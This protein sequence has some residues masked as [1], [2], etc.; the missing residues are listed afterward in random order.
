MT[1]DGQGIATNQTQAKAAPRRARRWLVGVLLVLAVIIIMPIAATAALWLRLGTGPVTL[2]AALT[3]R[4]TTRIDGAMLANR[5]AIGR[6]QIGR[7]SGDAGFDMTIR[8]LTMTDPDGA[9]RA[10]FPALVVNL[11]GEALLQGD[12]APVRVDLQGAGLRLA[13]DATG[14]IDLALM[15]GG[16]AS[17][18]GLGDSLA[19]LERMLASPAFARLE[20]VNGR[21]LELVMADAMTGQTMR[22]SDARMRLE[23]VDGALS[24]RIGGALEGSRDATIDIDLARSAQSGATDLVFSFDG[25]AARD[26]ATIGPALAWV[27]LLRAPISGVVRGQLAADGGVGDLEV[28][29]DIGAGEVRPSADAAPIGFDGLQVALHY[30]ATAGRISFDRFDLAAPLVRF[31]ANGH[32]DLSPD[33][34]GY[35]GQFALSDITIAALDGMAAPIVLDTAQIDLALTL[36]P[37]LRVEIGQAVVA[38]AGRILRAQGHVGAVAGGLDIAFDLA[39]PEAETGEVLAYWP[40]TR[41]PRTRGWLQDNVARG[42][43]SDVAFSLRAMPGAPIRSALGLSFDAA[44]IRVLPLMPP[45]RNA[46]GYLSI[47]DSRMVLRLDTGQMTAPDGG[48]VSF[49]GSVMQIPDTRQPGPEAQI[50]LALSGG[51]GDVLTLLR[52]PPVRLLA[53]G[54]M[55]TDRLGSGQVAATARILTRL[56]RQGEGGQTNVTV[57]GQVTDFEAAALVPGRRLTADRLDITLDDARLRIAGEAR[58]DGVA[59]SGQWSRDLGPD[60]ARASRLEAETILS[61]D[62]LASVGVMLPGWMMRG[63]SAAALSLDLPDDAPPVLRISSDLAGA[64]LALP[65]LGW[66]QGRE[67]TGRMAVEVRLGPDPAVTELALAVDGLDLSGRIALGQNGGMQRLTA[68]RFR[69]GSWLDVTG[70]LSPRGVG[71]APAIEITGGTL[72]LRGAPQ[73]AQDGPRLDGGPITATLDRLQV[74][75]G[76]AISPLI[77]D[78]TTQG[79]LSGQFRGRVN[80]EAPV[81]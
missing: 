24:L 26:I 68:D 7:A 15:A 67:R 50:D 10:A 70:A 5:I 57:T 55:T 35:L 4:I 42:R 1:Q 49:A 45:I 39:M 54:A 14:Q 66:R 74:T 40:Q 53:E 8:D 13:R 72:D 75:E 29:L 33:G 2:P 64:G 81:T 61:R 78:L 79:G 65:P 11:S 44:D 60:A 30:D 52:A 77:A 20:A 27:D 21:G 25:L 36:A 9:I 41:L 38:H 56:M 18:I 48:E 62:R 19:R 76:I 32:A 17:E 71:Q 58:L 3:E 69:L 43:L 31:Q 46:A 47:G 73:I 34:S 12:V 6:I 16:M 51:L 59:F 63:E 37:E 23:R 28:A 80:G 22:V